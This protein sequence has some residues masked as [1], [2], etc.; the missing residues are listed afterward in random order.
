MSNSNELIPHP[1]SAWAD[2]AAPLDKT[3]VL[4]ALKK[5]ERTR[6]KSRPIFLSFSGRSGLYTA[7]D[8]YP[9][10]EG[11][12]IISPK[13][14]FEG[15]ILWENGRVKSQVR[16]FL[17]EN[18]PL[19]SRDE[20]PEGEEGEW[21]DQMGFLAMPRD[22]RYLRYVFSTSSRSGLRAV[23][24]VIRSVVNYYETEQNGNHPVILFSSE[25][26]MAKHGMKHM[27]PVFNI[28]D[29]EKEDA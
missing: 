7:S 5:Y 14:F 12:C 3:N 2:A 11:E 22:K 27:K 4:A 16:R 25:P 6:L 8:G 10:P 13:S 17:M 15:Y 23:Q 29:W 28:V 21:R 9:V 20:F 1:S 18:T 24:G 26:F 19:P